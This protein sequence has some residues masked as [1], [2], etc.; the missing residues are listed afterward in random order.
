MSTSRTFTL[1]NLIL[2][3]LLLASCGPEKTSAANSGTAART[4]PVGQV[5]AQQLATELR[6]PAELQPY[7][8]VAAYSKVPGFVEWIG[9]DRG[10]HVSTGQLMV[11]LSA[12][13]LVSQR[14]EGASKLQSAESQLLSAQA[15]QAADQSTYEKLE[16]ASHT[17]GVV[18]G[19]DLILAQKTTQADEAQ[20]QALQANAQAARQ[21]LGAIIETEKYLRITAPF[22]GV[23]TER[24][25]HPGAFVGP[26]QQMPMLRIQTLSRLRLIVPVPEAYTPGISEG[27]KVSFTVSSFPDE[28]FTGVVVRISHSV[29]EKTRTMPVELDVSNSSGRLSPGTFS[30]VRWPIRRPKPSLFVP[31]SAIASNLER[32]FVVRIRDGKAEWVDVRPGRTTEKLTE[33][34]GDLH[35]NDQVV[36]RATDELQPGTQ[37]VAQETKPN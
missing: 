24:N 6:L 20:V 15:K 35:E 8:T 5:V 21:A 37:V 31:S 23:V 27:A 29:D 9:V 28:S 3:A 33:V 7:E 32:T 18:A 1:A 25:V 17:P 14:A 16:A 34:F 22:T 26:N 13:E 4:V 10:S 30:E 19:N 2:A 11:R 36:L 12:P